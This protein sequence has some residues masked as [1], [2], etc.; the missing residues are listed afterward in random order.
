MKKSSFIIILVLASSQLWAQLSSDEIRHASGKGPFPIYFSVQL[1]RTPDKNTFKDFA[2]AYAQKF[3]LDSKNGLHTVEANIGFVINEDHFLWI[4]NFELHR[5]LIEAG[6]RHSWRNLS[7]PNERW[8]H[9]QEEVFSLRIGMRGNIIYP[10]TYQIQAGPTFHNFSSVRE[11]LDFD[12]SSKRLRIG[13]GLF[14]RLGNRQFPSGL[15]MRARLMFLDPS[16]TDGGAGFYVEYR[17][18]ITRG[19]RDLT[20]FYETFIGDSVSDIKSWNYS[21]VTIGL[22]IPFAF[23]IQ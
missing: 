16:G 13:S 2:N 7:K 12:G 15:D 11:V 5:V 8:I 6:Y 17:C 10:I 21:S 19:K 18:L 22:V 9:L 23:R 4:P 1:G 14:E 20:R 3:D